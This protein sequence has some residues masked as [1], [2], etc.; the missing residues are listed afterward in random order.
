MSGITE[1]EFQGK[2]DLSEGMSGSARIGTRYENTNT[3]ETLRAPRN[4]VDPV[5]PKCGKAKGCGCLL[6]TSALHY[7][8]D[9]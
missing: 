3:V 8:M 7:D 4:A 5:C 9:D 6:M 1:D 2:S